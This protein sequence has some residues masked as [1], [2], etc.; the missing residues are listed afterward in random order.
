M[1]EQGSPTTTYE[2]RPSRLRRVAVW[3]AGIAAVCSALEFGVSEVRQWS[4]GSVASAVANYN[5]EQQTLKLADAH[6][7]FAF[8]ETIKPGNLTDNVPPH[9]KQFVES[10]NG[11]LIDFNPL[12]N[13]RIDVTTNIIEVTKVMTAARGQDSENAFQL[14][15]TFMSLTTSTTRESLAAEDIFVQITTPTDNGSEDSYI[16]EM[17]SPGG[18]IT[19]IAEFMTPPS[20]GGTVVPSVLA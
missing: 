7:F 8:L 11:L 18:H 15:T 9:Y 6:K 2:S 13:R 19:Y 5:H 17:N 16:N 1:V 3:C 20:A 4:Q 14:M 12:S 10:D